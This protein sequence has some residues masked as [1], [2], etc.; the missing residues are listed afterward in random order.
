M[1]S[2]I[3]QLRNTGARSLMI[4]ACEDD[5]WPVEKLGRLL[6][7]LDVPVFGGIFPSIIHRS[8]LHRNGT[9]LVGFPVSLEVAVVS[10]LRD[11]AG[12]DP[13]VRR[14]SS[15]LAD[16]R[17][18]FAF[19]DGLSVNLE[20]FVESLFGVVGVRASVIG[21][22]AGHLDLIQRP[23]LLGNQGVL[24]DS[25]LLVALPMC[26]DRGIAHGWELLSGPFLVTRSHGNV[27]EELNYRPAFEVYRSEVEADS[28]MRFAETDFFSISKTYPLGIGSVDGEFLVRDPIKQSEAALICVGDVPE[29]ATIHLLKG[30]ASALIAAA[31]GAAEAALAMRRSRLKEDHLTPRMAMIFDCISRRL[32]LDDRFAEELG[33]I[34]AALPDLDCVVGVLSIGEIASSRRGMI[35][36]MNKS[37]LIGLN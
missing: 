5:R 11:Q 14:L 32:F 36:L 9:I 22:G 29:N 2:A 8:Q 1:R 28:S 15:T 4:L 6:Q 30:D 18:L 3:D 33:A 7:S 20:T 24:V 12:I 23:C 25:A 10:R 31:G 21:G 27:L 16:C 37:I 13:Q 17:S 26:V 35:E 34:D 19:V